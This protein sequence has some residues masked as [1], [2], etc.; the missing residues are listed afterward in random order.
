MAPW[1]TVRNGAKLSKNRPQSTR[2]FCASRSAWTRLVGL[3]H[4]PGYL[5]H[6]PSYLVRQYVGGLVRE[7]GVVCSDQDI[8]YK[9]WK[10]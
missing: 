4:Q 7:R 5:V 1:A 6:Q 9:T 8:I 2:S 10:E 3:M